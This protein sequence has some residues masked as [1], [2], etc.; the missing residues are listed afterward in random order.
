MSLVS[1][2][3]NVVLW[4]DSITQYGDL[5]KGWVNLLREAY[6]AQAMF[7]NQGISGLNSSQYLKFVQ[8]PLFDQMMPKTCDKIII[9]L[10]ANDAGYQLESVELHQG[11]PL[12]TFV[13]NMSELFKLA[14]K[15]TSNVTI[16]LPP[17]LKQY[18]GRDP[19]QTEQ[20]SNAIKNL[21]LKTIDIRPKIT[22]VSDIHVDGIHMNENGNRVI[23]ETVKEEIGTLKFWR[24]H[25]KN[26]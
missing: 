20:Y 19:A 15:Y 16:M 14:Q 6:S 5:S 12:S 7:T 17:P 2:P 18:I 25:W 3:Y 8:D 13:S 21:N 22:S 26:W 4:G 10:G 11:V 1:V 9:C 24:E 23:F